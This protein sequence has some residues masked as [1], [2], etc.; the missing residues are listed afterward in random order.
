VFDAYMTGSSMIDAV[1]AVAVS[2]VASGPPPSC[3]SDDARVETVIGAKRKELQGDEYC[4]FRIYETLSDVDGDRREDF[5]VVFAIEGVGGGGNSNVQF[6]AVFSSVADWKVDVLEVARRG[7]RLITAIDA[8]GSKIE[9]ATLEYT[10]KDAM[11][12]P[13]KP[14]TMT[15]AFRN[16]KLQQE[17]P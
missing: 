9:L 11:C 16:G 7:T 1:L 14:G 15:L 4:Q 13:S 10:D 3:L 5:L 8:T 12:C 2:L 17:A 6:L